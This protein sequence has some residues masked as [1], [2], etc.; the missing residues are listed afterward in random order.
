MLAAPHQPA[1]RR[2]PP[3]R[4]RRA[5]DHSGAPSSPPV[6]DGDGVGGLDGDRGG[7]EG[8]RDGDGDRDGCWNVGVGSGGVGGGSS[9]VGWHAN[10]TAISNASTSSA[11]ANATTA[12]TRFRSGGRSPAG[13]PPGT[14]AAG[15]GRGASN[16]GSPDPSQYGWN[17]GP[18]RR[19][20]HHARPGPWNTTGSRKRSAPTR[21]GSYNV[22]THGAGPSGCAA[23]T[24][25]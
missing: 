5:D 20:P 1:Q 21:S 18:R 25:A 17:C 23:T 13:T 24:G 3:A 14:G 15:P 8:D 6:P 10:S 12:A 11:A 4:T 2:S 19:P 22:A 7:P 16:A 9:A